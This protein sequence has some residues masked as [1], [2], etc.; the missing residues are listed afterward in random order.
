MFKAF[1]LRKIIVISISSKTVNQD[2]W[3]SFCYKHLEM[4][5]SINVRRENVN[6]KLSSHERKIPSRQTRHKETENQSDMW[7]S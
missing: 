7:M 1:L 3:N 5:D 2:T 6:F 4:L